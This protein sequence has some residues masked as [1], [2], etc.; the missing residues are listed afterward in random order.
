MY[1][2][3]YSLQDFD[4]VFWTDVSEAYPPQRLEYLLQLCKEAS[5]R[6]DVTSLSNIFN[7]NA[8]MWKH[9]GHEGLNMTSMF[10]LRVAS[11]HGSL[12]CSAIVLKSCARMSQTPRSQC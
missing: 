4:H 6:Q 2:H 8:P 9:Y 7:P 3:H 11:T 1:L 10:C 5:K 12:V